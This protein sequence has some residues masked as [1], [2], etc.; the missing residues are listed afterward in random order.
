MGLCEPANPRYKEVPTILSPGDLTILDEDGF[1]LVD[2]QGSV[3]L[4]EEL[5]KIIHDQSSLRK[6]NELLDDVGVVIR[7][8]CHQHHLKVKEALC[9]ILAFSEHLDIEPIKHLARCGHHR[10]NDWVLNAAEAF[11]NNVP[12]DSWRAENPEPIL[13]KVIP[14]PAQHRNVQRIY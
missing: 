1:E 12:P 10:G 9:W 5:L 14:F 3:E 2:I 6:M 7:A 8:I 11:V 4:F 13:A